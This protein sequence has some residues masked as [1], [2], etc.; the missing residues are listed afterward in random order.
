MRAS[1]TALLLLALGAEAHAAPPPGLFQPYAAVDQDPV[2]ASVVEHARDAFRSDN[3]SVIGA[4]PVTQV[5]KLTRVDSLT[6]ESVGKIE[7]SFGRGA[8][9]YDLSTPA[10]PRYL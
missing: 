10:L 7:G 3:P 5:G 4:M 2:C 9:R 8:R 1:M 6:P